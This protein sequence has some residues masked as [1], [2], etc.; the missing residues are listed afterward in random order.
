VSG[1]LQEVLAVQSDLSQ[2]VLLLNLKVGN[3]LLQ[4]QHGCLQIGNSLLQLEEG[5]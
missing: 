2:N 3:A 4:G 5:W 1:L